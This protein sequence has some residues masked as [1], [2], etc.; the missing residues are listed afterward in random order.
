MTGRPLSIVKGQNCGDM[1]GHLVVS[2][3]LL[4]SVAPIKL[5]TPVVETNN[6]ALV[7]LLGLCIVLLIVGG[8]GESGSAE[9]GLALVLAF[10]A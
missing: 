10:F 9:L 6:A 8:H 2:R 4:D 5:P 7:L 1:G 3:K